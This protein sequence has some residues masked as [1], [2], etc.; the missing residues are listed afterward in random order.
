M[1]PRFFCIPVLLAAL[2][3]APPSHAQTV[4]PKPVE[5]KIRWVYTYAEGQKLGKETGKPLFVVF[6][7]ER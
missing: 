6:R 7:C 1:N 5:G 4:P 3:A 2:V